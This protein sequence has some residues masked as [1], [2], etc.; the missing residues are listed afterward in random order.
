MPIILRRK[1][2]RVRRVDDNLLTK[3][4]RQFLLYLATRNHK[5]LLYLAI[6]RLHQHTVECLLL[7]ILM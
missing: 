2:R 4:H 6:R 5:M 3:E 7:L 1:S